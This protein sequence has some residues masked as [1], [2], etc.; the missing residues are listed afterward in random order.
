MTPLSQ[1]NP[2]WKGEKL[3]ECNETIGSGGCFITSLAILADKTPS[4]VNQILK[5]NGGY[6][7]G[8]LLNS[9]KA[10]Q[11]LGLEYNGITKEYQNS[12]CIAETDHY[13]ISG[14]PQHFFVWLGNGRI[15]D[16]LF[17]VEMENKYKIISFRLF[18][19]KGNQMNHEQV[20]STIRDARNYL[21]GHLDNTGA[22]NDAKWVG[23]EFAKGNQ[24]A[25]GQMIKTYVTSAEFK[26]L[27]MKK[28]DCKPTVCPKPVVCP[29]VKPCP[30]VTCDVHVKAER[31]RI[32]NN[33]VG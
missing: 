11:L 4:E 33:L 8:C 18:K 13:K 21:F 26:S 25:L 29:P 19:P 6:S 14:V 1:K 20:I 2:V 32:I 3:G 31:D 27:W 7:N 23:G 9:D 17:G 16:P 12:V 28:V 5:D 30:V 22:E 10:S 24:Y 15:I